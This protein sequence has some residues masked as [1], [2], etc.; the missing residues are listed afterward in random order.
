M[1]KARQLPDL[2]CPR[3]DLPDTVPLRNYGRLIAGDAPGT[4]TWW[5]LHCHHR[6]DGP[7]V[8]R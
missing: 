8:T 3:C 2:P 5:C 7:K 6:F 1:A 4:F